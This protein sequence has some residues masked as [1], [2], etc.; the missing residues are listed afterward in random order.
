MGVL[1]YELLVGKPPY[2]DS[3]REK[4][5]D[6]INSG[7]LYIPK[8]LTE[9]TKSLLIGLLQKTPHKRLGAN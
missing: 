1:F 7:I 5:F 4:L 2:Y 6:N 3:D 8:K 9:E